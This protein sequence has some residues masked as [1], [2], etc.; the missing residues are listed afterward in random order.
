VVTIG[1]SP[2]GFPEPPLS[3]A[4]Q[5]VSEHLDEL[6]RRGDH[7]AFNRLQAELWAAGTT[8]R[9]DELDPGFLELSYALN[10]ENLPHAVT[11]V[12]RVAAT[13]V[14]LG[15]LTDCAV[16]SLII[17]GEHDLTPELVAADHLAAELPDATLI[18]MPGTAHSPSIE[19]PS[20]FLQIVQR[21]LADNEL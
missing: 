1:S 8:R 13:R 12:N 5:A 9:L 11:V 20:E 17:V 6:L 7:P 19:R 14:A 21:W 4:E 18:R 3:A 10:A 16:P 2:S 15:R